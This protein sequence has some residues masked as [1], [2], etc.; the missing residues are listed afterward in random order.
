MDR[1]K[2]EERPPSEAIASM[3]ADEVQKSSAH[4]HLAVIRLLRFGLVWC[5]LLCLALLCFG[6]LFFYYLVLAPGPCTCFTLSTSVLLPF[7]F[8]LKIETYFS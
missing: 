1:K 6:I 5:G 8:F 4:V 2:P 3:E 7:F